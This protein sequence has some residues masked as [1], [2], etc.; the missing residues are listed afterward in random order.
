MLFLLAIA[1]RG[2]RG[3]PV[4]LAW[5][6]APWLHSAQFDI[7]AALFS[8]AGGHNSLGNSELTKVGISQQRK[9]CCCPHDAIP[10]C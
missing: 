5:H 6:D 8:L 1:T 2:E 10:E 9:R 4:E 7:R 3:Q